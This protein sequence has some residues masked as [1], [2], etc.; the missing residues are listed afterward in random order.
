MIN[1]SNDLR[2]AVT[3]LTANV[4]AMCNASDINVII[5]NFTQ[6]KDKLIEIYKYNVEKLQK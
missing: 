3:Y 5:Q 1:N 6:A 4:N 2:A